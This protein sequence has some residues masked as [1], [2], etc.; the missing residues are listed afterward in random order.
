M[1]IPFS[2]ILFFMMSAMLQQTPALQDSEQRFGPFTIAARPFTIVIYSKRLGTSETMV[3]L[4]IRDEADDIQY[5]RTFP[6]EVRDGAFR[7]TLSVS[8]RMV[9]GKP[10]ANLQLEY[11]TH[12]SQRRKT[13][14]LQIFG[15][16][17]GKL[18]LVK[19]VS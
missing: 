12:P 15:L 4:E 19:E 18:V 11:M 8:A 7:E 10:T 1:S 3:A 6:Y 9:A 5:A 16:R 2:L 14:S 13:R 17:D